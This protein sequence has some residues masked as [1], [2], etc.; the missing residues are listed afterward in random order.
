MLGLAGVAA[1]LKNKKRFHSSGTHRVEH[2]GSAALD[3]AAGVTRPNVADERVRRH[4]QDG[5]VA[6]EVDRVHRRALRPVPSARVIE[7]HHAD[8][9][10]RQDLRREST[11][12]S[13]GSFTCG[14]VQTCAES[15][16][17]L[18]QAASHVTGYGPAPGWRRSYI[19]QCKDQ[20]LVTGA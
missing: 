19:L 16:Q 10:R 11:G 6:T 17:V 18:C 1:M 8:V 4:V 2:A 12:A 13:P 5:R 9:V 15:P 20:S 7:V 14:G 3:A